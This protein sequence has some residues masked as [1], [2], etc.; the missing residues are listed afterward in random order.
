MK[1]REER[2]KA[3]AERVAK[4][5]ANKGADSLRRLRDRLQQ[6]IKTA[7][8]NIL[9]FTAKSKTANQL[10]DSMQRKINELK[11]QLDEI[12]TKMDNED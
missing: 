12:Q 7:E 6:E 3:Q 4:Q 8:N 10:V 5:I 1:A 2:A 9:F 11:K